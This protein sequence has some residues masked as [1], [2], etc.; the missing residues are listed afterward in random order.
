MAGACA[1]CTQT[2]SSPRNFLLTCAACSSSWHHRCHQPVVDDYALIALI[3]AST[4]HNHEKGLASWKCTACHRQPS[5]V[6]L[7]LSDSEED[8]KPEE[9][10]TSMPPI[11]KYN[12]API[13]MH[14]RYADSQSAD[15]WDRL[16]RKRLSHRPQR[17]GKP[18]VTKLTTAAADSFVFSATDWLAQRKARSPRDD[19]V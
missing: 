14:K 2:D 16:V 10:V 17:V 6:D 12:L 15:P 9:S 19:D 18:A 3:K 1:K 7:T 11:Y 4:Q 13:W 5:I 8:V